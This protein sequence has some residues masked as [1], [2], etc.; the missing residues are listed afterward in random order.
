[1]I[2]L[3]V[4]LAFA[5]IMATAAAIGTIPLGIAYVA[6]FVVGALLSAPTPGYCNSN[7][8]GFLA[9]TS[10]T[11][12]DLVGEWM[13]E[14]LVRQGKSANMNAT[15]FGLMSRLPAEQTDNT[16]FNWWERDPVRR[17]LYTNGGNLLSNSTSL[18]FDDGATGSVYAVLA[19]NTLLLNDRTQEIIRVSGDP[20]SDTLTVVRAE[21]GTS[22]VAILDNDL[23]TILGV[24]K[25]EGAD[26]VRASYE[27]PASIANYIQTF[28]STVLL[29]N[30]F[31]NN[32]LRTDQEG[33]KNQ[34]IVQALE[35]IANDIEMTF[36]LGGKAT[37][38][39]TNGTIFE[40]GGIK[41]AIDLAITADANL[42]LNKLNGNGTSGVTL[43]NFRAWIQAVLLNGSDT[44]IMFCGPQ[45][46]TAVSDFAN[47]AAGGFRIMNNEGDVFGMNLTNIQTPLGEVSLCMHPLFK[48]AA[49]LNDWAFIVD[50]KLLKQKVME[51]LFYEDNIQ[52]PGQD[53]YKGQF[54]AK[55]GLKQQFPGAFGYAYDLSLIN[56]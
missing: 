40:M 10:A 17:N 19:A 5:A 4:F 21:G 27:Q 33:P 13:D 56:A 16:T 2:K 35:K 22:G 48:N 36:F 23:W 26:P 37:K 25:D 43:A 38:T 31:K 44:K 14:I 8:S 50:L 51:P 24:A 12:N 45:A 53:S 52:L 49:A 29:T 1:M 9:T 54:R 32:V 55:L 42:T 47:S 28:N 30:A 6:V 41:N 34:L 46:F 11:T 3:T 15:L 7:V 18:T 39:G 20:S